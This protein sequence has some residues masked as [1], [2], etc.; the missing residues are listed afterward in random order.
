MARLRLK[1]GSILGTFGKGI[2]GSITVNFGVSGGKHCDTR[3]KHHPESTAADATR[4]C[5]AV[6]AEQRPD[7]QQLAAKLQRHE[8]IPAALVCGRALLEIQEL[9][10]R[11]KRIPWL[12]IST[13]GSLPQPETVRGS[14]LFRSQFRALLQHCQQSGIPVHIPVET[15][16]K[17]RFYDALVGDL[18]TIRESAQ[19]AN[20]FYRAPCAVSFTAGNSSQTR[21][22][23]VET[24][25]QVAARR[26]LSTGRKSIVC[27]AVL[28]SFAAKR[29]P[30][31]KNDRAK[32]GACT[33][34]SAAE[35]DVVYPL[36]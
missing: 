6:R 9:E 35:V 15:A 20:R 14:K 30:A 18:V 33:A 21:A 34:C 26:R 11:G 2:D 4:A 1:P 13:N 17:R 12:R 24:A 36:H 23:R 28:N 27:P 3:C 25:R 8:T 16:L 7:R 5:Y 10:L 19:T 22:E 32:C 29:N 31:L